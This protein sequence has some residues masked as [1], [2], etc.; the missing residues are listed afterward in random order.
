M[1]RDAETGN[2]EYISFDDYI[3]M[4]HELMDKIEKLEKENEE[5]KDLIDSF[6]SSFVDLLEE[7]KKRSIKHDRI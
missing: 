2:I 1:Y 3:E 4:K 6:M 7:S 5:L